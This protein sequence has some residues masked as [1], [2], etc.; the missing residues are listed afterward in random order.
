MAGL[1]NASVKR[2]DRGEEGMAQ[3]LANC[4]LDPAVLGLIPN[5]SKKVLD[6]VEINQQL[7]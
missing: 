4:I 2:H 5:V 1:S 7:Y 3:R 6:A